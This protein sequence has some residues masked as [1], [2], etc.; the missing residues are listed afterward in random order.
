MLKDGLKNNK[1]V[2]ADT[3]QLPSGTAIMIVE[4]SWRQPGP[5]LGNVTFTA[6]INNKDYAGKAFLQ[7]VDGV[8]KVISYTLS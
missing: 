8:W 6:N 7:V 1:Y 4:S 5:E 3:S 2:T